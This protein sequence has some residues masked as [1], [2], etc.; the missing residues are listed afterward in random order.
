MAQTNSRMWTVLQF[1]ARSRVEGV[2]SD[3]LAQLTKFDHKVV[4]GK[5]RQGIALGLM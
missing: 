2:T 3:H 4:Y 5:I 1:I